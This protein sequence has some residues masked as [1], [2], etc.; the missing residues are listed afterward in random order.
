M[1]LPCRAPETVPPT[2][3]DTRLA[4]TS[5]RALSRYLQPGKARTLQIVSDD[6]SAESIQIPDEAFRLLVEIL[7]QMSR[8]NA[9]A[10]I[11]I[12]AELTTQGAADLLKVSRPYLIKLL[13]AGQIPFRRV[14]TR[15]KICFKDLANYERD[16]AT[17]R[18]QAIQDLAAL[19]AE[20]GI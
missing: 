6:N 17:R 9:V 1:S 8:G 13:E 12:H 7:T 2:E 18:T 19:D 20:L 10:L 5:C 3:Q 14:G 11:P 4:E 16:V 15:R